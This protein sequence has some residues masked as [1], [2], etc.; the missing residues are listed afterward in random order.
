MLSKETRLQLYEIYYITSHD[1]CQCCFYGLADV[2]IK[3]C[4]LIKNH[5]LT[6]TTS[7]K[8]QLMA[9]LVVS[10]ENK[11]HWSKVH[12]TQCGALKIIYNKTIS[13]QDQ[14]TLISLRQYLISHRQ[15]SVL[16]ITVPCRQVLTIVMCPDHWSGVTQSVILAYW[17]GCSAP[18]VK[19]TF[20]CSQISIHYV[21]FPYQA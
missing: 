1:D 6:V 15:P 10:T 11:F 21:V 16:L 14:L 4:E 5:S 13:S 19:I 8:P 7:Y 20:Q 12:I 9:G 17:Y 2:T 18:Q 3:V